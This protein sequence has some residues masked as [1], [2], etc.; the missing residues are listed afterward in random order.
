MYAV[1]RYSLVPAYRH[2]VG[3]IMRQLLK[4]EELIFCF[5]FLKAYLCKQ[6]L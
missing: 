5:S 6:K 2:S 3:A 4:K 1:G